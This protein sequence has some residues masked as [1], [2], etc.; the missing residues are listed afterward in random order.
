MFLCRGKVNLCRGNKCA[1]A[2]LGHHS[3]VQKVW[4]FLMQK[5]L[6]DAG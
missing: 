1:V 3:I 2:A 6:F 4:Y 5:L